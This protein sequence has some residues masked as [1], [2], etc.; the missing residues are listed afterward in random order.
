MTMDRQ[1]SALALPP[2]E[3]ARE[4]C[5]SYPG[6]SAPSLFAPDRGCHT[7]TPRYGRAG[8]SLAVRLGQLAVVATLALGTLPASAEPT[9]PIQPRVGNHPGFGRL[10]F[11]FAA[12]TT[13]QQVRAG[14]TLS[15][16]FAADVVVTPT[17]HPPHNVDAMSAQPGVVDLVVAAGATTHV[18]WLGNRLV[19]DVY[20]PSGAAAETVQP[21]QAVA[22]T[23]AAAAPAPLT[24]APSSGKPVVGLPAQGTATRDAPPE[25]PVQ[26]AVA[27]PTLPL[28]PPP[29]PPAPPPAS[30]AAAGSTHVSRTVVPAVPG[31]P[32]SPMQPTAPSPVPPVPPASPAAAASTRVSRTVVPAAQYASA[33]PMLPTAPSQVP[34]VPPVS[35]A[36]A[37]TTHVSRTGSPGAQFASASPMLPS[38]PS[39]PEATPAGTPARQT[40][41]APG[42]SGQRIAQVQAADQSPDHAAVQPA[43]HTAVQPPDHAAV[44]PAAQSAPQPPDHAA[45]QPADHTAVRRAAQSA[46][47]PPDRAAVQPPDHAAVQPA[48]QS[49]VQPPD[50][51]AVQPPDHAAAQPAA[52]STAQPPDHAAVQPPEHAAV[53]PPDD[54]GAQPP[55]QPPAAV[56]AQATATGTPAS[57]SPPLAPRTD[58]PPRI[59]MVLALPFPT[60]VGVAAFRRGDSALVVFDER[61]QIDLAAARDDPVFGTATVELLPGATVL[62]LKLPADRNLV[63]GETQHAWRVSVV[64]SASP[65]RP[66]PMRAADGHLSLPVDAV[67]AV[68]AI[69]DPNTGATLLVGT[70]RATGQDFP[71]LHQTPEFNLLPTWQGVVVEP[72][73]DSLAMRADNSGFLLTGGSEGLAMAPSSTAMQAQADASA[74]T[75]RF[76]LRSQPLE[77]LVERLHRQILA[78]ATAPARARG[79]LREQAA[80]TLIALGFGAEAQA[81]LR[82]AAADDPTIGATAS[83]IGLNAI[84]AL[85]DGRFAESGGIEDPRLT[86]SDEVT[87]WRAVRAAE[88]AHDSPLAAAGFAVVT[89]LIAVY[90]AALRK[91]L[92]PQAFETMIEGGQPVAAARLLAHQPDND[93]TLALARG[94]LRAANGD[95]DGALAI[96]DRLA[97]GPDR[98][99][100]AKAAVRAV[101]LRLTAARI[102]AAHAADALDRLLYSWRGGPREVALRERIAALR[103]QSGDWVAAL[104]MLHEAEIL[105]PD[106]GEAVHARLKATFTRLLQDKALDRLAPLE[107]VSMVEENADLLPDGPAGE[108]LQERLAD[109][110]LALDLP[111]RAAPVLEKL[112]IVAPSP[113]GRAGFGARLAELRLHEDDAKG[114]LAALL[115]SAGPTMSAPPAVPAAAPEAAAGAASLAAPGATSVVAA[116]TAPVVAALAASSTAPPPAP[117]PAPLVERR[118]LLMAAAQARLGDTARAVAELAALGTAATDLARATILEQ[119][120]DWP[121]AEHALTDYVSKVVPPTGALNQAQQQILVRYATAAAEAGDEAT[122]ALLRTGNGPRM[123]SGAFG[124]MF[125]LLTAAPVQVS[126]D[127]PRA[128]RETALAHDLPKTLGALKPPTGM[129]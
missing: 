129:P 116:R 83:A 84:A 4:P 92:L 98:L 85:L 99:V 23:Q 17:A 40:T 104:E 20:D 108:A 60:S 50:Q 94:M 123:P 37:A 10:V 125:R 7:R 124:D 113:A 55:V 9:A 61:R 59:G 22:P 122:L 115:A 71:T 29:A 88:S 72:L 67:G 75:R 82:I 54:A 114:A 32:A 86:G 26:A 100:H 44:Q 43:D 41:S 117:L 63:I 28:P 36:A 73:A 78:S 35:P 110:L 87:L 53:Q 5:I 48:A 74:M 24:L 15:L 112:T 89:P 12:R 69:P 103:E 79:R 34:P 76:D 105:F 3:A 18:Y 16:H 66:I 96:Y 91:R 49:A 128:G 65:A 21:A 93:P 8:R 30:P 77:T 31:A 97:N 101:E 6:L 111:A 70:Q 68:V 13:Y 107:L 81:M 106:D 14:D 62:H 109:R 11:D 126:A 52:Q 58:A 27:S 57:S 127:L 56:M 118:T 25:A 102:D 39:P 80:E 120:K 1:W 47:Q 2:G 64:A 33:S 19:V 90:P 38:A 42:H 95:T 51:A 119:A 121:G 45:I 46:A